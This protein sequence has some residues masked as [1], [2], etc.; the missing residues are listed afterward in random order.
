MKST[1]VPG[2]IYAPIWKES[3]ERFLLYISPLRVSDYGKIVK[4]PY[5]FNKPLDEATF[6]EN[7]ELYIKVKDPSRT[8]TAE[9]ELVGFIVATADWVANKVGLT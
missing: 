1:F 2:Y 5:N 6:G 9:L 4:F 3:R 8:G 7:E